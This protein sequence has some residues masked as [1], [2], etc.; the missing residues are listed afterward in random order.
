VAIPNLQSDGLL[1]P[2]IHEASWDEFVK[3]FGTSLYRMN[4]I[5]GLLEA[6]RLLAIAGCQTLYVDG[7]FVTA[8]LYPGDFDACWH[9]TGVTSSLVDPVFFDFRNRRAAQ[10]ARFKGEL[11]LATGRAAAGFSYLQFFQ[12]DKTSGQPKGIVALNLG[13]L[14]HD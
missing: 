1:P 11:F 9:T 6:S 8:K 2:G 4:I 12:R 7:S 5:V 10:K 13:S 14:P 3:V